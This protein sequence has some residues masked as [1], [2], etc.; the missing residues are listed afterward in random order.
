MNRYLLSF[1]ICCAV[2]AGHS[3]GVK[4]KDMVFPEVTVQKNISYSPATHPGIKEKHYLFDLYEPKND[5]SRQRPLIIWLHGGGFKFG[6]KQAKGITIWS[7]SFARRGYVCAA[8]NYRLSKN[9]PLFNFNELKTSAYNAVQ[10]VEEAI[11]FF[12][13][14]QEKF[15]IDPD[16]IFLAGNSAGGMIALQAAYSS[17]AELGSLANVQDANLLSGKHNPSGVAGVIN[18]WGGL[19]NIGWLENAKVPFFS[20]YGSEDK[21]VPVNKKD[22]SLYGSIELHRRADE[23]HIP[24]ALK[25]Y[26]GFSHELQKHFNPIFPPGAGTKERWLDAGQAAADFLSRQLF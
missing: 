10:D 12:K 24:N 5:Q 1:F 17:Q 7:N 20:A 4:Y 22:T 21:I 14:N 9:N 15:G 23:L 25:V 18:F 6:S 13:K 2:T 8:L 3:Q 11:A 19:F 16:R 26:Q